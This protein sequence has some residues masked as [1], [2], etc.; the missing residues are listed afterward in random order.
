MNS[1][2]HGS[3]RVSLQLLRKNQK[4]KKK[5]KKKVPSFSPFLIYVI[6]TPGLTETRLDSSGFSAEGVSNLCVPGTPLRGQ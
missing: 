3:G 4:K 5:K 2:A 6:T 1:S